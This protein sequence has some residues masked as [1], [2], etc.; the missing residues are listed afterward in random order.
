MIENDRQYEATRKAAKKFA[1]D[2]KRMEAGLD[3]LSDHD[4]EG[5]IHTMNAVRGIMD[6]LEADLRE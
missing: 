2:L 5:R 6:E 3:E 4:R 1:D